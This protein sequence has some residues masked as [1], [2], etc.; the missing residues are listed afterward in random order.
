MMAVVCE[1]NE[2][3]VASPMSDQRRVEGE[4]KMS[5]PVDKSRNLATCQESL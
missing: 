1:R 3:P 5:G 4:T 2:M